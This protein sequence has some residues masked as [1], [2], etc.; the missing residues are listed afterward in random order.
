MD[1]RKDREMTSSAQILDEENL[2]AYDRLASKIKVMKENA[3]EI[4]TPFRS[5]VFSPPNM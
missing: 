4:C 2:K 5:R 3:K 1:G